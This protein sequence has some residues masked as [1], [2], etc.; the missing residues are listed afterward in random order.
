MMTYSYGELPL[1]T[2][3]TQTV[4]LLAEGYTYKEIAHQRGVAVSTVKQAIGKA[5]LKFNARTSAHLV[6]LFVKCGNAEAK[7]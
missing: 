3:E 4:A 5:K 2:I 7:R 1:T 6:A